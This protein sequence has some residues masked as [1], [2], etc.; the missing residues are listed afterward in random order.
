M[1]GRIRQSGKHVRRHASLRLTTQ[2]IEALDRLERRLECGLHLLS[3]TLPIPEQKI[4]LLQMRLEREGWKWRV[5]KVQT[6]KRKVLLCDASLLLAWLQLNKT[7]RSIPK[8]YIEEISEEDALEWHLKH[9]IG[10]RVDWTPGQRAAAAAAVAQHVSNDRER[11]RLK[12]GLVENAYTDDVISAL[13]PGVKKRLLAYSKALLNRNLGNRFRRVL[14]GIPGSL[15]AHVLAESAPHGTRSRE[16]KITLVNSFV[17]TLPWFRQRVHLA[18]VDE[19]FVLK[20]SMSAQQIHRMVRKRGCVVFLCDEETADEKSILS[21]L[22][23]IQNLGDYG[24]AFQMISELKALRAVRSTAGAKRKAKFRK[25]LLFARS[26]KPLRQQLYRP[27]L[28]RDMRRKRDVRECRILAYERLLR[29]LCPHRNGRVFVPC[30]LESDKA[31]DRTLLSCV[32]SA[33]VRRRIQLFAFAPTGP[34]PRNE[35]SI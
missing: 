10:G 29:S 21:W 28:K 27:E 17:K 31:A 30:Y 19:D 8:S 9:N 35:F 13:C 7:F 33:A 5:A 32:K 24:P 25:V 22:N 26:S 3:R 15:R 11:L 18:L 1:S 12:L 2:E 20:H 4:E 23:E 14:F 16:C 6:G 34:R